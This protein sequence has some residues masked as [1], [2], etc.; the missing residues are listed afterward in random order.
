MPVGTLRIA[1][2]H[3]LAAR[4]VAPA[5]AKLANRHPQIHIE[6][7]ADDALRDIVAERFDLAVRLGSP[8]TSNSV[9][10]RLCTEPEIVVAAPAIVGRFLDAVRP[11]DLA[12]APWVGHSQLT[13]PTVWEFWSERGEKDEVPIKPRSLAN[14]SAGL[15]ALLVGSVGFAVV[16]RYMVMEEL[17]AGRLVHVCVDWRWRMVTLYAMLPTKK[18]TPVRVELFVTALREGLAH[19]GMIDVR[20]LSASRR[21]APRGETV[22]IP[23]VRAASGAQDAL[24]LEG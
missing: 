17:R 10:R 15:L 6:I 2:T 24:T 12:A 8:A 22:Q 9:M 5:A 16:P 18:H 20:G 21:F 1:T 3:D 14:T 11:S 4:F 7:V 13:L 19:A 23:I